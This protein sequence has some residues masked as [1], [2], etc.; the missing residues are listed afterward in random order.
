MIP[1]LRD[2]TPEDCPAIVNLIRELAV[3][4][5]LE[6]AA[7]AT[8]EDLRR[9]LFGD[10]AFAHAILVEVADQVVGFAL[11][12]FNFSTFRGAPGLYLED[13]FVQPEHRGRGLGKALLARLAKIAVDRGCGR[14]EWSVLDWNAPS[15]GFYKALGAQA[16]DEWTMFRMEGEALSGL[17]QTDGNL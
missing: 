5:K 14:F 13:L 11:Y 12:F 2:A 15:I 3:Y 4:E 9:G 8:A 10:P 1:T 7:N 17:A 6:H 16:M